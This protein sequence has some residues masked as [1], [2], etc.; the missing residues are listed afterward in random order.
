MTDGVHY[1]RAETPQHF[2]NQ[3]RRLECDA[4]LRQNLALAGRQLVVERY[5]W[6]VIG[7][8][9]RNA[10]A[11]AAQLNHAAQPQPRLVPGVA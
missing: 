7:D 2:V 4:A 1:L 9:L 8:R 10:Y 5:S 6:A 11:L 3:I